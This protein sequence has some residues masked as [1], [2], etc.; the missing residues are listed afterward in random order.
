MKHSGIPYRLTLKHVSWPRIV[1]L[2]PPT[3]KA[4][5]TVRLSG[6]KFNRQQAP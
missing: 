2:K 4:Q 5:T 6:A 1:Q 3:E